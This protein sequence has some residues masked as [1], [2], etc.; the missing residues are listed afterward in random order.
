[1]PRPGTTQTAR[2]RFAMAGYSDWQQKSIRPSIGISYL[3]PQGE[4]MVP[5]MAQSPDREVVLVPQHIYHSMEHV[6]HLL[7]SHAPRLEPHQGNAVS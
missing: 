6:Q 2:T 5:S 7:N 3:A 4:R 1:M